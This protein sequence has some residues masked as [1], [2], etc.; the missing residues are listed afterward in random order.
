MKLI[1]TAEIDVEGNLTQGQVEVLM[2]AQLV[3]MMGGISDTH[4]A[5][6]LGFTEW[7]EWA[8]DVNSWAVEIAKEA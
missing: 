2:L 3:R 8:I 7:G 6:R 5:G 1:A 4:D